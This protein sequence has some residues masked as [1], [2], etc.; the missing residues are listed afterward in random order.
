MN[1]WW[2][3]ALAIVAVFVELVVVHFGLDVPRQVAWLADLAT[4]TVLV[5]FIGVATGKGPVGLLID[6]RN[7]L[8]LSRLQITLWTLIVLSAIAAVVLIRLAAGESPDVGIPE[9]L[10]WAIGISGTALAG[11]AVIQHVKMEPTRAPESPRAGVANT[12]GCIV[13]N[14]SPTEAKWTDMFMGEED[15]NFDHLEIGKVQMFYFTVIAV[16]VYS[17]SILQLLGSD[18]STSSIS[19]LP[20]LSGGLI[21]LLG[22]SNGLY[23]AKKA[24]P[25]TPPA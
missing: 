17:L 16:I 15:G 14:G 18:T 25:N 7:K 10:L 12:R 23:L 13:V 21:A 6:D 19:S 1:Q 11:T 2:A 20:E 5:G 24:V 3:G 4:F 9:P 8:S 22:L